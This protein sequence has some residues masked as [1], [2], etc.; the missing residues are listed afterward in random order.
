MCVFYMLF[1]TDYM[2]NLEDEYC[3]KMENDFI[4]EYDMP[5]ARGSRINLTYF[6]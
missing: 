1:Y 3:W 5:F 4:W 6:I 2:G